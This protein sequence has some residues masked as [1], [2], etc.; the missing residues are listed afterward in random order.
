MHGYAGNIEQTAEYQDKALTGRALIEFESSYDL[1]AI[2]PTRCD[3]ATF[4]TIAA[5]ER[6]F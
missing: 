5:G 4:L 3:F 1:D 2:M 6:V